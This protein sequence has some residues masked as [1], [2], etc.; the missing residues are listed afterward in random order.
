MFWRS[1]LSTKFG[2]RYLV[3]RLSEGDEIWHNG[4]PALLYISAE[5]SELW[6]RG[7]SWGAKILKGIHYFSRTSFSRGRWNLGQ[8]GYWCVADLK[9]FLWW[10]LVHFSR[11]HN[12]LTADISHAS[13]SC[14]STA[15]FGSVSGLANRHLFT[16]YDEL[17]FG[18]SATPCG[19]MCRSF[20]D[21]LRSIIES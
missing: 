5:V 16:E 10:F 4:S 6:P 7:S 8:W 12:F 9:G 19:D 2:R 1:R 20:A 3:E 11:E 17:W 21:A 18:C 15:K 13:C 14:R